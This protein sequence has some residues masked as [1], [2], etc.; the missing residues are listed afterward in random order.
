MST[1]DQDHVP[2]INK[3]MKKGEKVVM[4]LQCYDVIILSNF[5]V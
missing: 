1:G 2:Q 5:D 3:N 4:Q